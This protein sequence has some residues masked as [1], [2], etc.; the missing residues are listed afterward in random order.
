MTDLGDRTWK[1][2]L[3]R[4]GRV[5]SIVS[6]MADII[7]TDESTTARKTSKALLGLMRA[8]ARTGG[9]I[10]TKRLIEDVSAVRAVS[11]SGNQAL[12]EA[13]IADFHVAIGSIEAAFITGTVIPMRAA[14]R[15]KLEEDGVVA[16]RAHPQDAY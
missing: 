9:I 4:M 14:D 13:L 16:R 10:V 8:R 3:V 6:T 11:G 2:G 1:E 15:K 7:D 12:A 5:D